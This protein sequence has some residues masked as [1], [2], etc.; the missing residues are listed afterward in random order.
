MD[1]KS[2]VAV[3][4]LLGTTTPAGFRGYFEQLAHEPNLQLYL[5]KS[6]PAAASP[7]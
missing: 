2:S 5:I 1:Q 3:D 4:F 7:R 6:G